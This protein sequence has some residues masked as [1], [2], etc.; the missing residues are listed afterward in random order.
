[1]KILYGVVGEGMGHAMRSRVV[2]QHLTAAGHEIEVMASGRAQKFLATRFED[3][4]QIHG[5][6]I[7]YEENRVRPGRT[8]FSNVLKG[9]AAVPDQIGAYFK[10][11]EDFRPEVVISDFESWT[12]FFAKAHG[13]PILSIDNMQIINRCTH[14]REVLEGH[15]A[16]FQL[17]K[18]FVKSKLPGCSEYLITTFF[19]PPI[20]KERTKLFPPILRPEILAAKA[21][22]GEHILVYGTSEGNDTLVS[23]LAASGVPCRI[24]GIRRDI[25]ADVT[26]GNLTYRPFSEDG[27]I[28]DMASSRAVIAGGGFTTMGEAVYL[29][30]PLLAVPVGGQFEQTLNARYLEYMG[31]GKMAVSLDDPRV[32]HEFLEAVPACEERLAGYTQDGNRLLLDEVDHFLDRAAAGIL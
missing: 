21:S 13:L 8:L 31:F 28:A 9:I 32:V 2:L 6:H 1:M 3:V 11:L 14:P 10:M 22:K 25:E 27:F 15:E 18:T 17:I 7:I 20:R 26:E 5:L 19:Y 23:A 29:R 24:Y 4:H 16:E 30:K 12:Y